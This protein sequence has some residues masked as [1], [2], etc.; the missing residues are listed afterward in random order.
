MFVIFM[1]SLLQ[2]VCYTLNILKCIKKNKT[3]FY[4]LN[5]EICSLTHG[6]FLSHFAVHRQF[7]GGPPQQPDGD[8]RCNEENSS[9]T[10]KYVISLNPDPRTSPPVT[11]TH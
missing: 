2:W 7:G 3:R 1:S 9:K 6:T 8:S 5:N 11:V 4:D 10:N